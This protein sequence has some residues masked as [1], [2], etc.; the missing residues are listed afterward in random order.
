MKLITSK[1]NALY[2]HLYKIAQG[3]VKDEALLEGYH[4][5]Q[6]YKAYGQHLQ[7]VI[8]L[9]GYDY[10]EE[11]WQALLAD[12]DPHKII[13]LNTALF[14]Q[15]NSVDS[16]QAILFW[17][18]IATVASIPIP[19]QNTVFLDRL[20]DP[21]NMGTIFRTC[22]AVGIQ[23]IYLS[24]GCVN[25]WS[26]KV[27]RSAQGAH[28]VL[29]IYTQVDTNY[30]LENNPLPLYITYLDDKASH[31]YQSSLPKNVVWVLGNEGQGV[32]KR[33]F[34]YPHQTIFIPQLEQVESLNVG[35]ACALVLY[36]QWRQVSDGFSQ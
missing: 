25:P 27:L 8:L 13:I 31:L 1:D 18:R 30:F 29:D 11:R 9:E 16:P 34:N 12:I 17:I 24:K 5:S 19:K 14:K 36:E 32:E 28:F 26:A 15:L 4:L 10:S 22:A 6:M 20:Q 21:G 23:S 7:G 3:K 33:F 35:V 2:K